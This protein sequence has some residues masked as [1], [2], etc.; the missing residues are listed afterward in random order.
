M[1]KVNTT[2]SALNQVNWSPRT[3][4]DLY[5]NSHGTSFS[6]KNL[7]YVQTAVSK[8]ISIGQLGFSSNQFGVLLYALPFNDSKT[9]INFG[10]F[11]SELDNSIAGSVSTHWINIPFTKVKQTNS[12]CSFAY[13]LFKFV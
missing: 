7:V 13:M 1:I 4:T 5:N 2:H 6:P 8:L 12:A 11:D 9:E 3:L 10:V